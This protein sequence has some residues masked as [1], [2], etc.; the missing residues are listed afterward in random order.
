[1]RKIGFIG[2]GM[3]GEPM[4]LNLQNA[5][6]HVT[7]YNRTKA[8]LTHLQSQGVHTTDCLEQAVRG[9]EIVILMLSDDRAV[10]EMWAKEDGIATYVTPGTICINMSTVSPD[11][12]SQ[13]A[14]QAEEKG[15]EWLDAPV[16]GSSNAAQS[17]NL[18]ILVGGK[19]EVYEQSKEV[20]QALGK[21]SYYFGAAASGAKAK[22]VVNLMMGM[23]MQG[24]AESL[25]LAQKAGLDR[26]TVLEMLGDAAVGAPFLQFKK[27]LLLDE[28]Y[29]TM[30]ALKHMYNDFGLILEEARKN[31]SVLPAT[32]ATNQAYI[33]A[34]N[35]GL[36]ELDL[37]AIFAELMQQSK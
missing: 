1:M 24:L 15:I 7:A 14:K 8:K 19:K 34:M 3:M 17:A 6:F 26:S 18:V 4:V 11:L 33:A 31:G 27:E 23:Y 13:L 12:T 28:N 37:S 5:G 36:G 30:F 21:A 20:F 9:K 16:S 2:I 25:V 29:E 35:H 22:L 32:S 10:A